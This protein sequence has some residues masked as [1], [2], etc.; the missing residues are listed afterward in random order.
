MAI[1]IFF[2]SGP[3]EQFREGRSVKKIHLSISK[4]YLT[5]YNRAKRASVKCHHHPTV[6]CRNM[7]EYA[8]IQTYSPPYLED[9]LGINGPINW[10]IAVSHQK[11]IIILS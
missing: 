11:G 5:A 8:S 9:P 6:F 7:D 3:A 2:S 4:A 1:I 10:N